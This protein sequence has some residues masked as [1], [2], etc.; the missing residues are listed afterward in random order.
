MIGGAGDDT[1]L[2][3]DIGDTVTEAVAAGADTLSGSGGNDLLRGGSG[4]DRLTG[5]SGSDKFRF[6]SVPTSNIDTITDF[7]TVYDTI[8]LENLIFN[9]FTTTGTLATG[10]FRASITGD[11][12]DANDFVLYETDTGKLFYD[13]DGSGAGAK[14]QIATL[15]GLPA[16]TSA[17][18]LVI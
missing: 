11:A 6:D 9:K 13:A 17:D 1:Y 12:L 3:D 10:N 5:G 2:V 18:F 16:L 14:V 4:N 8:Q 15:V 7:S